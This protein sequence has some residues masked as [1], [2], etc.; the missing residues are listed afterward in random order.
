MVEIAEVSPEESTLIQQIEQLKEQ[1]SEI[2]Q[3]MERVSEGISFS[4]AYRTRIVQASEKLQGSISFRS[5]LPMS[6]APSR[7]R[8]S[9]MDYSYPTWYPDRK[10]RNAVRRTTVITTWVEL[11]TQ[12]IIAMG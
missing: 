11:G 1:M 8:S 12:L 9:K 3:M 6:A 4:R 7:S 10:L 5:P 2:T